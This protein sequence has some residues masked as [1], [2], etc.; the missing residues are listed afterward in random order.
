MKVKKETAFTMREKGFSNDMIAE[1]LK[2]GTDV[3]LQW[4]AEPTAAN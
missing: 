4:F 2:V 1:I 3:I